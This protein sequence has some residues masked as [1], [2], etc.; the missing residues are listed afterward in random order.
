MNG[1]SL[2]EKGEGRTLLKAACRKRG[3]SVKTIEELVRVEID[4]VGRV[5]RRGMFDQFDEILSK[6][7]DSE[8]EA[9]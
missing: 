6:A 7:E 9:A 3:I 4:Q 8:E 1:I 2:L 5:R